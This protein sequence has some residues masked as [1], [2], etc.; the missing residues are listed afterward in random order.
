MIQLDRE[1]WEE[2]TESS[3]LD[4]DKNI[5]ACRH[6]TKLFEAV[7]FKEPVSKEAASLVL[8][9]LGAWRAREKSFKVLFR[10]SHLSTAM[11]GDR[12]PE[13]VRR[14]SLKQLGP[15]TSRE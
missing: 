14:G 3:A 11:Y 1:L 13:R 4:L 9:K 12:L 6:K 5:P 10:G 2:Q 7:S 15:P 8:P